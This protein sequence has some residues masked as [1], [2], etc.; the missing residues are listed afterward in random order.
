[1]NRLPQYHSPAT[2]TDPSATKATLTLVG[3]IPCIISWLLNSGDGS[4]TS[5]KIDWVVHEPSTAFS[6][7]Q[8]GASSQTRD[9]PRMRR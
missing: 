4:W 8:V 1:M 5:W 2:N 3:L 9:E 7:I 6:A